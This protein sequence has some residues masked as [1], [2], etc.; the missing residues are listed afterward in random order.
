MGRG[1]G[2]RPHSGFPGR[3]TFPAHGG[4]S[5]NTRVGY[6][7]KPPAT[8]R[9]ASPRSGRTPPWFCDDQFFGGDSGIGYVSLAWDH[10]GHEEGDGK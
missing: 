4:Q 10:Q 7:L 3:E 5:V 9:E 6:L 1:L 2:H 8:S